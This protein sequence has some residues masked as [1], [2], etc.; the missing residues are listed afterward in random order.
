METDQNW[1]LDLPAG[2]E[3]A[4]SLGK[5][6]LMQFHR[7]E[8][9]GCRKL[10]ASTY[11][12]A[13]VQEE[14]LRWFV[15]VRQDIFKNRPVRSSYST[16][17]TPSFFF[18]DYRGKLFY[19]FNGFLGPEDFRI[20]LRLGKAALEMLNRLGDLNEEFRRRF[21][22]TLVVG[23]AIHTGEVVVGNIGFEKKMDY[24]V[25]GDAVNVLFR[26]QD[27]CHVLPDS[28]LVSGKTR[29]S[30]QSNYRVEEITPAEPAAAMGSTRVFRLLGRADA[31]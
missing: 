6:V 8:C 11:P 14:L 16:Y 4:R 2:L 7:D 21:D 25:I 27:L 10:Y 13:D 29:R 18:L 9:A 3:A 19:S 24:T 17:W 15:P 31:P 22:A 30:A 1:L 20:L 12:D 26:I 28:I 5:P 23:I